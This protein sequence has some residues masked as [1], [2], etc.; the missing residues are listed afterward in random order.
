MRVSY[1][2]LDA[3][4]PAPAYPDYDI[5]YYAADGRTPIRASQQEQQA[6]IGPIWNIFHRTIRANANKVVHPTEYNNYLGYTH[7]EEGSL[8]EIPPAVDIEERFRVPVNN[9]EMW[10]ASKAD[11]TLIVVSDYDVGKINIRAE[12]S[13]V[14]SS[15]LCY[16]S[17]IQLNLRSCNVVETI[18][19][20]M[21]HGKYYVTTLGLRYTQEQRVRVNRSYNVP[22][23]PYSVADI[24]SNTNWYE[25]K[26]V[27]TSTVAE[28]DSGHLDLLTTAAEFPETLSSIIQGFRTIA[29]L[30]KDVKKGQLS[31]SK[32]HE[33]RLLHLRKNYERDAQRLTLLEKE[34]KTR[35]KK[36]MYARQLKQR[37]QSFSEANKK[38]LDE[39]A[40]ALASIWMNFRYNIM[41]NVYTIEDTLK[42]IE[43][44][45]ADFITGRD[46]SGWENDIVLESYGWDP[47]VISRRY[48][49]VIKRGVRADLRLSQLVKSNVL[50]TAWEMIPLSF[51][52]DWFINIGDILTS[53]SSPNIAPSEG[54]TAG[55]KYESDLSVFNKD[56]NQRCHYE[57]KIYRRRVINPMNHIG[58]AFN[59]DLSWYRKLDALALSWRPIRDLLIH[60]L[61]K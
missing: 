60:S 40:E 25:D 37:T 22:V 45:T 44:Y 50:T 4:Q 53:I 10:K 57:I 32:A 30:V 46:S 20:Y 2:D 59:A 31:V 24:L 61:K 26:S 35:Y 13:F 51:V 5:W 48:N 17:Y 58:L 41:P 43:S 29:S 28:A 16:N 56:I 1:V 3:L 49:C 33:R 19:G 42:L 47:L 52:V 9:W 55:V 8:S 18:P 14:E 54:A 23:I 39:F 7:L 38:A 21:K 27:I 6:I 15:P 11:P 34:A 36:R 12:P